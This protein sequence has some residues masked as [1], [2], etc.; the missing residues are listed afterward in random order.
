MPSI[1]TTAAIEE[2]TYIVTVT[3][4]DED[5]DAVTFNSFN[6]T[7]RGSDGE[8]VNSRNG[9]VPA[10][11][12]SPINIVLSGDDLDLADGPERTLILQ[13]TYDSTL[14]NNLPIKDQ[15]LINIKGLAGV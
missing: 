3:A 13:A 14:G 8:V 4:T 15:V 6:W 12:E 11:L 7:L 2:S 5:G 9:I 10:S 1:L